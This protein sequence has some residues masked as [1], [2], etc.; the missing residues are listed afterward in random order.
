[1]N[2]GKKHFTPPLPPCTVIA[3]TTTRVEEMIMKKRYTIKVIDNETNQVET[4]EGDELLLLTVEDG[5]P[6]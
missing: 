5:E 2:C 4:F 6:S 3:E 1:M